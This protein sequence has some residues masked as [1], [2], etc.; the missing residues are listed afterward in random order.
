MILHVEVTEDDISSGLSAGKGTEAV[1]HAL[2]RAY[3][4]D[5][6]TWECYQWEVMLKYKGSPR[7]GAFDREKVHAFIHLFDDPEAPRPHTITF[8]LSVT[9]PRG[10]RKTE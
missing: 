2:E 1:R 7:H 8:D 6:G 3:P 10:W 5:G 4:V 9:L